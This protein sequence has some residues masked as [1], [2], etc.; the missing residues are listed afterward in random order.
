M[1]LVCA[2]ALQ[3]GEG[4]V[5]DRGAVGGELDGL[6]TGAGEQGFPASGILVGHVND[7]IIDAS[8]W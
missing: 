8:W 5:A 3:R 7:L 6:H 1:E 4:G 2:Y